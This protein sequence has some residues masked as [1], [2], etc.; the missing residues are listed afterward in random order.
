MVDKIAIFPVA[1]FQSSVAGHAC[2]NALELLGI[3]A[4][5][6]GDHIADFQAGSPGIVD[7]L[8]S[9]KQLEQAKRLLEQMPSD[10]NSCEEFDDDENESPMIGWKKFMIW[11]IFWI[12]IVGLF[13]TIGIWILQYWT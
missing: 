8:V 6:V 7:V 10:L 9:S 12:N 2:A 13:G 3:N 4:T 5:V 1:S 11:S